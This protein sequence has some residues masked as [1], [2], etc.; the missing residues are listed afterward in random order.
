MRPVEALTVLPRWCAGL[1]HSRPEFLY[2]W[3]YFVIVNALW[4]VIPSYVIL[5]TARTISSAIDFQQ[6][7]SMGEDSLL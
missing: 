5:H 3:F 2:F 4:I 6:R 7:C 1:I